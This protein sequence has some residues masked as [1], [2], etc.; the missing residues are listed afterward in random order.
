MVEDLK[1]TILL[2][3]I[4]A[5][6]VIFI[7]LSLKP[8]ASNS[9]KTL[10]LVE[11]DDIKEKISIVL[12]NTKVLR[13]ANYKNESISKE[14]ILNLTLENLTKEDAKI[15]KIQPLKIYC[16][17][18]PQ[19]RF[20]SSTECNIIVINNELFKK[21]IIEL[22]DIEKD[23]ELNNYKYKGLDCQN[24]GKKYYC[25]V[26][27]YQET[28]KMHSFIEKIEKNENEYY[29]YEYNIELEKDEEEKIILLDEEYIKEHGIKYKHT[30]KETEEQ[31]RLIES[32]IYI[33]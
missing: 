1:K 13:R 12:E 16:E 32:T 25:L 19:V 20:T 2:S 5:L 11:D 24:D 15:I 8:S 28:K 10:E 26:S 4:V 29:V 7:M 30:F 9:L 21:T 3:G 31:F 18:T 23:I 6:V 33:D 27:D 17:V 14:D 22:L